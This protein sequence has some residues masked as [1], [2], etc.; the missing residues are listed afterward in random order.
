MTTDEAEELVATIEAARQARARLGTNRRAY[1]AARINLQLTVEA[2]LGLGI[3]HDMVVRI[4]TEPP[5]TIQA[6][7][8]ASA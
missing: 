1:T 4:L 3:D 8:L 6:T 2:M 7:R 5:D